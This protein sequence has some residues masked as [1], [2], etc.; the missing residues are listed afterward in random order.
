ME[1]AAAASA[2][3]NGAQGNLKKEKE[4]VRTAQDQNASDT[5]DVD[6]RG[7]GANASSSL[8]P[9]QI[10]KFKLEERS[11]MR[12]RDLLSMM[13]GCEL[14]DEEFD[15]DRISQTI[16]L[17]WPHLLRTL[18]VLEDLGV[19]RRTSEASG[20][21]CLGAVDTDLEI[22]FAIDGDHKR[23]K[24]NSERTVRFINENIKKAMHVGIEQ[25][26]F[27]WLATEAAPDPERDGDGLLWHRAPIHLTIDGFRRI[28]E[29]EMRQ[30]KQAAVDALR[31]VR[32]RTSIT[33]DDTVGFLAT[34]E[35]AARAPEQGQDKEKQEPA[36]KEASAIKRE[37]TDVSKTAPTGD[38]KEDDGAKSSDAADGDS[39][40][41]ASVNA[42]LTCRVL[43]SIGAA[44]KS[45][46]LKTFE[47][48][49]A[50]LRLMESRLD[51]LLLKQR[52]TLANV[53][54]QDAQYLYVD[55]QEAAVAPQTGTATGSSSPASSV[56]S[57]VVIH[58]SKKTRI[59]VPHPFDGI[60][61]GEMNERSGKPLARFQVYAHDTEGKLRAFL[62]APPSQGA[63]PGDDG[64]MALSESEDIAL[65]TAEAASDNGSFS[66]ESRHQRQEQ[67]RKRRQ[68]RLIRKL[69]WEGHVA[70][71][72][73]CIFS[74]P[75]DRTGRL[76]GVLGARAFAFTNNETLANQRKR[77]R[78]ALENMRVRASK[79]VRPEDP[80][81]RV[82]DP[83]APDAKGI[84]ELGPGHLP[85]KFVH[86]W[87]PDMR[88]FRR[89]G[90]LKGVVRYDQQTGVFKPAFGPADA[91]SMSLRRDVRTDA[92]ELERRRNAE[93]LNDAGDA[94]AVDDALGYLR[95][96]GKEDSGQRY[97]RYMD[98]KR[99]R[100]YYFDRI[101]GDV[102]W[103]V[104]VEAV[105]AGDVKDSKELGDYR[106]IISWQWPDPGAGMNKDQMEED[107]EAVQAAGQAA[108]QEALTHEVPMNTLGPGLSPAALGPLGAQA[109]AAQVSRQVKQ[110][111][112]KQPKRKQQQD[113]QQ[114][115]ESQNQTST[116]QPL[117]TGAEAKAATAAAAALAVATAANVP[118]HAATPL[119]QATVM[120]L[121]SGAGASSAQQQQQ[122]QQLQQQLQQQQQQLAHL[123]MGN[124][125]AEN[126]QQLLL[127]H[128]MPDLQRN[129]SAEELQAAQRHFMQ[130]QL[131]HHQQQ[132]QQQQQQHP[133]HLQQQQLH[134][135]QRQQQLHLLHQ[136]H[137]QQG[138][139]QRTK[140]KM[141][142]DT[143]PQRALSQG[144]TGASQNKGKQRKSSEGKDNKRPRKNSVSGTSG[145]A[146][147]SSKNNMNNNNENHFADSSNIGRDSVEQKQ[148]TYVMR[149]HQEDQRLKQLQ[150][151]QILFLQNS[152][153]QQQQQQQQQANSQM[154][155]SMAGKR[156]AGANDSNNNGGQGSSGSMGQVQATLG[157]NDAL[158]HQMLQ[159][160]QQQLLGSGIIDDGDSTPDSQV[161]KL[162]PFGIFCAQHG[163][164]PAS[165][166]ISALDRTTYLNALR[167]QWRHLSD[168]DKMVFRMAASMITSQG[169]DN[170]GQASGLPGLDPSF[171]K[172]NIGNRGADLSKSYLQAQQ[173]EHQRLQQQQQQQH[174]QQQQQQQQQQEMFLAQVHQLARECNLDPESIQK[175]LQQM[176]AQQ[177]S[178]SSHSQQDSAPAD[179]E[180]LLQ[181][182]Q[183]LQQMQHPHH[184]QQQQQHSGHGNLLQGMPGGFGSGA[185]MGSDGLGG[186]GYGR[187]RA[188]AH[189][190]TSGDEASLR[191]EFLAN[192]R[193]L[194]LQMQQEYEKQW[195]EQAAMRKMAS[196]GSS[197]ANASA[198]ASASAG[199]KKHEEAMKFFEQVKTAF[200]DRPQIYSLFTGLLEQFKL[201]KMS[202]EEIYRQVN[203][204]FSE[205]PELMRSFAQLV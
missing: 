122:Q 154:S 98:E 140:D 155:S 73:A 144:S 54:K 76:G 94:S 21:S 53:W 83:A 99:K 77:E 192:I 171:L 55:P 43:V 57:S 125:T 1:D 200:K 45:E 174:H 148:N 131:Q 102:Q 88:S 117:G 23:S 185:H 11:I 61:R 92:V 9:E 14:R 36:T 124:L 70:A 145:D 158:L 93:D 139:L 143:A 2:A 177:Q 33:V 168:G 97:L 16:S 194:P 153:G 78:A 19:F 202:Y 96:L 106:D 24:T 22:S 142:S 81:T 48:G 141:S 121:A 146:S 147:N 103:H 175:L 20:Q 39:A 80:E 30:S 196:S 204:L 151:D 79:R 65:S 32:E 18:T 37:N 28:L 69:Q 201:G 189:G 150:Q 51:D 176:R 178:Q 203:A 126:I 86:S 90:H 127:Q 137:Q 184:Q 132:Q 87:R 25:T 156:N 187:S 110:G 173:H 130:L 133:Q 167:F 104:P 52:E 89:M 112:S 108:L 7:E 60:A 113:Q 164:D 31:S 163:F 159:Q 109:A 46:T 84:L 82:F 27:S 114:Q 116:Q 128:H 12:I 29:N 63:D 62:L 119:A 47:T 101:T 75:F 41:P 3:P 138:L 152:M 160:Q 8:T 26:G 71:A 129:L 197:S 193:H 44:R 68:R 40:K 91:E 42:K 162:S 59:S 170:A 34:T 191:A 74:P 149:R 190:N 180:Q 38:K 165:T 134:E 182:Q 136:Q 85:A 6:E 181:V 100:L 17:G 4:T 13:L 64:T 120:E 183:Y 135:Q 58:G 123:G 5:M 169:P 195:Q 66:L 35:V 179:L 115:Q 15:I 188:S 111:K 49:V 172:A 186:L 118:G 105:D 205:H 198:S 72:R 56:A 161:S 166:E 95:V 10:K 67:A 157:M 50:Q 107:A 199:E